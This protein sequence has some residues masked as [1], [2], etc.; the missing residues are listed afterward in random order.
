MACNRVD[1]F[2][3]CLVPLAIICA[4]FSDQAQIHTQIDASFSR[5]SSVWYDLGTQSRSTEVLFFLQVLLAL[6]Q[7]FKVTFF[8]FV[9]LVSSVQYNLLS[10]VEFLCAPFDRLPVV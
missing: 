2:G 3:H 4:H 6:L 8:C 10:W 7:S 9:Q 5:M 1:V